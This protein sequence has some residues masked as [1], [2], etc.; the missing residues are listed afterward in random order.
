MPQKQSKTSMAEGKIDRSGAAVRI[1]PPVVGIMTIVG[2]YVLGKFVPILTA[3]DLATPDRYW[4]GGAIVILA[5]YFLGIWPSRLF[6][7]TGQNVTPWSETPEIIIRGPYKFTRNPMYLM[8]M[9]VNLGFA[10]ILSEAWIVV[11]M[12]I[13]VVV[14]YHIAIKHEEVYLEEQFGDSY[15]AYKNSVRRWI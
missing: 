3:F 15:R 11:F 6:K 7:E 4:I 5:G 12:P 9:L 2:G 14:L 10:V 1:P 8:M 13:L